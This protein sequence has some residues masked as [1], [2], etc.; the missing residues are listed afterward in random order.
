MPSALTRDSIRLRSDASPMQLK[1][2][3]N[4]RLLPMIRYT[5]YFHTLLPNTG[6]RIL[7]GKLRFM[8]QPVIVAAVIALTTAIVHAQEVPQEPQHRYFNIR[9]LSFDLE[10]EGRYERRDVDY[11][12]TSFLSDNDQKN[13]ALTFEET[14]G[15]S[16]EFDVLSRDVLEVLAD[17]RF[18]LQQER[19]EEDIGHYDT[20][21]RDHGELIEFDINAFLFQSKPVAGQVFATRDNNR[22]PRQFL[23]SL[24]HHQS[25][26][27][28]TWSWHNT[29]LPMNLTIS[30]RDDDYTGNTRRIDDEH[31][32]EDLL[33]YDATWQISEYH[34]LRLDYEHSRLQQEFQGSPFDFDTRRDQLLLNHTY[35]FGENQKNRLETII[36]GQYE[37]GDLAR[38]V[39]EFSPQLTLQHTDDLQTTYKYLFLREDFDNL[40]VQTNRFDWGLTHQLYRNLTSS[41]NFYALEDDATGDARTFEY[42]GVADWAYTRSNPLGEFSSHLAYS[43]DRSDTGGGGETRA[44]LNESATFTDPLPVYLARPNVLRY[45]IVV[46][47]QKRRRVYIP[48]QDYL[49]V[50][51]KDRTSLTRLLTGRIAN[52]ESILIHYSYRVPTDFGVDTHRVD[53]RIQQDFSFGLTPYYA[54][55]V[56]RQEIDSDRPFGFRERDITRHRIGLGYRKEKWSAGAEVELNDDDI[57]PFD[58]VHLTGDWT[59]LADGL[60]NVTARAG[61]S[62]FWFREFDKRRVWLTDISMD[63]EQIL[64]QQW[65]AN[66]TAL[67]RFESDSIAGDTHG[68]DLTAALQY[69]LNQLWVRFEFEYDLLHLPDTEEQGLF[70][71]VRIERRFDPLITVNS[72]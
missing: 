9:E 30:R 47:D 7:T 51:R 52:K 58:A 59:I 17:L 10:L 15:L 4:I 21:D 33:Q 38:D 18:G 3:P 31:I 60:R 39:F 65:T 45:T 61:S 70:F 54:L 34:Q 66:A 6:S 28:T 37:Q 32:T 71:W 13:A 24:D 20:T 40:D 46:T 55:T 5:S 27:G 72:Q 67:Y 19:F 57:D 56:Q 29:Q 35:E 11:D 63:Y 22:I 36:R 68:V 48:G 25:Y 26:Y 43:F 69:H 1:D 49:I 16:T 23:P 2:Q 14:V 44:V 50:S 62:V 41:F 42:G 8:R 12:E 64:T 53:F